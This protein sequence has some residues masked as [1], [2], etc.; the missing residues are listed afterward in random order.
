MNNPKDIEYMRA[1]I[2]FARRGLG[3]VAP[4]PSVGCVL[5]KD[6]HVIARGRTDEGG[7]PHAEA[8]ALAIAGFEAKGA[9]AYITLEPCAAH[10]RGGPCAEALIKAG[11]VRAVIACVDPN[12]V[13]LGKGIDILKASSM[14]VSVGVLEEEAQDLNKGF[15]LRVMEKR[16]L[17]TLKIA[18]TKNGK[19]A[20]AQGETMAITGPLARRHAHLER[21][22][23]DAIL[24]GIGTVLK[25][26]PSLTTRIEGVNHKAPRIILDSQ[27]KLPLD[28]MLALS[29]HDAPVWVFYKNDPANKKA[30]LEKMG[31]KLF[32]TAENTERNFNNISAVFSA[33]KTLAD[34]GITRLLV[35]G[36][37][38]V[39][40]SFLEA[41]LYDRLLWHKA[42]AIVEKG[43]DAFLGQDME[44]IIKPLNRSESRVLG[45]D[46]LEIYEKQA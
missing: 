41:G 1:A 20:G 29:A 25:D 34:E 28:S 39:W 33:V 45:E 4:N 8:V 30:A 38:K 42:P 9:T 6:G 21:A 27:L 16:P 14:A 17:I 36:G 7:R 31:V 32:L 44:T 23:H 10:G 11:I 35:E 24:V 43:M 40:A 22:Q 18:S 15:I 19:V 3:R 12:P 46:L 2:S 13:V 5:V 26:N 37:P